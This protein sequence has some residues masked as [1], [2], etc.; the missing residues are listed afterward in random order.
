MAVD[1]AE[2][3]SPSQW[4]DFA[5]SDLVLA[6]MKPEPG[7]L[8]ES[9]CFHAQQAAEKSVKA[10]LLQYDVRFPWTHSFHALL[11][12][13]PGNCPRPPDE[14]GIR[15]LSGHAVAG[16]YP[17]GLEPVTLR[18]HRRAVAAASAAFEWAE[19]IVGT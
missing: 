14:D 9:L 16:R 8:L 11:G 5:R 6:R 10:V 13:L 18:Q 15:D 1:R 17:A 3:G 19:R 7:V 12:L 4:L 2:P